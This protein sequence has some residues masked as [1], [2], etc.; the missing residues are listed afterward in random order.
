LKT[1]RSTFYGSLAVVVA[2]LVIVGSVGVYYYGQLSNQQAVNRSLVQELNGVN[3]KYAQ[4]ASEYNGLLSSYNRTISLLSRSIAVMN[5]S[6]PIYQEASKELA[7][8]WGLYLNLKP[9]STVLLRNNVVIDFGN[10]TRVWFNDTQVQ[11]GW[12]LYVETVVL[13]GGKM[14]AQWYPSYGEHFVTAIGGVSNTKTAFWF[15]W[16]YNATAHWQTAQ[17]GADQLQAF[18]GSVYAWTFCS[19]PP[20]SYTPACR[21]P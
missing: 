5:T 1:S 12:N 13:T 17:V 20:P 19:A 10:G 6:Q 15:L 7:A 9:A 16:T 8:L 21:P 2:L 18:N 3:T 4:L 14:Q 11:P